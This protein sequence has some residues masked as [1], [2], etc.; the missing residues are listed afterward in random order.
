MGK[1]TKRCENA[2]FN[3]R[4]KRTH[5]GRDDQKDRIPSPS[6]VRP[7]TFWY[8]QAFLWLPRHDILKL[9]FGIFQIV[10]EVTQQNCMR[11]AGLISQTLDIVRRY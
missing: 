3:A 8:S 7:T 5:G 6:R 4:Q 9:L 2:D 10:F 1:Q 11:G